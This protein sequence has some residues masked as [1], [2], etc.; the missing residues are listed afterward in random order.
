VHVLY[1]SISSDI[2]F[3]SIAT[4]I[5]TSFGPSRAPPG[6]FK[7]DRRNARRSLRR[8]QRRRRRRVQP[9][10]VHDSYGLRSGDGGGP[11]TVECA[12]R[13]LLPPSVARRR[14]KTTA[15]AAAT[16]VYGRSVGHRF[17]VDTRLANLS[18]YAVRVGGDLSPGTAASPPRCTIVTAAHRARACTHTHTHTH[19]QPCSRPGHDLRSGGQSSERALENEQFIIGLTA[20][21]P[22]AT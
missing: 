6:S 14:T 4:I 3:L 22:T 18:G 2:S 19:T 15:A 5:G 21:W 17:V 12:R 11:T 10:V 20:A 7:I 8:R 1:S 16:D 13:T 9:N